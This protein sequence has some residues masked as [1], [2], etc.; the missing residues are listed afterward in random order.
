MIG[1]INRYTCDLMAVIIT[2]FLVS[3][4]WCFEFTSKLKQ[5]GK[6]EK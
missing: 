5:Q 3:F 2:L 4:S 6:Q 1:I